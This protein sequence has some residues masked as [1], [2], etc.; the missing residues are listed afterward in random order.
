MKDQDIVIDVL[1]Q[2]DLDKSAI[3]E[4]VDRAARLRQK[5]KLTQ[6]SLSQSLHELNDELKSCRARYKLR[7]LEYALGPQHLFQLA[8]DE[9]F[10]AKCEEARIDMSYFQG[11]AR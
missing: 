1:E 10:V 7:K 6:D 5:G 4:L 3:K 2:E 11:A 9:L 8:E